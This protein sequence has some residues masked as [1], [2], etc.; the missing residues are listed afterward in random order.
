MCKTRMETAPSH[1][2]ATLT[3]T[4]PLKYLVKMG[5]KTGAKTGAK[6]GAMTDSS[7]SLKAIMPVITFALVALLALVGSLFKKTLE[8]ESVHVSEL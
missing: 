4:L 5:A 3:R 6:K 2:M 1:G 7:I 8:C